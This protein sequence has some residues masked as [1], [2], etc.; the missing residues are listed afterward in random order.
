MCKVTVSSQTVCK[1]HAIMYL[2]IAGSGKGREQPA[3]KP[4]QRGSDSHIHNSSI[5]GEHALGYK[6]EGSTLWGYCDCPRLLE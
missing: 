1:L 4:P 6:A 2:I 5:D 3:P